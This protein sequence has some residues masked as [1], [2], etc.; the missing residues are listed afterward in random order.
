MKKSIQTIALALMAIFALALS[1]EAK[2][3]KTV[4]IQTSANCGMCKKS[5]EKNLNDAEGVM[6]ADLDLDDK[7]CTVK[8]DASKTDADKIRKVISDTGYDADDVK[9]NKKAHSKLPKCCQ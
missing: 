9:K 7:V 5:I 3:I 1:A 8:Y 2:E 6:K 4:E